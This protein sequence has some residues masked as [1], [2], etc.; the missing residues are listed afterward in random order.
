[1]RLYKFE[2]NSLTKDT[3][4]EAFGHADVAGRPVAVCKL[5]QRQVVANRGVMCMH[6]RMKHC[7]PADGSRQ[8]DPLASKPLCDKPRAFA[9]PTSGRLAYVT[10]ACI[11]QPRECYCNNIEDSEPSDT[12]DMHRSNPESAANLRRRRRTLLIL[13]YL[14]A[15]PSD[16]AY[17]DIIANANGQIIRAI[18]TVAQAYVYGK[19]SDLSPVESLALGRHRESSRGLAGS[20]P[21]KNRFCAKNSSNVFR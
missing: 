5:C 21:P 12:D 20:A 9:P 15:D 2:M 11:A 19:M 7:K 1:M 10:R 8:I 18:R 14:A 4:W 16:K 6:Y 17:A 3:V 13:R